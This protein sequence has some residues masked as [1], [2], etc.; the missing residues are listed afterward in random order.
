MTVSIKV[1][2]ESLVEDFGFKNLF[3]VYSGRRGVHCWV[4]D[5][6]ARA[7]TAEGRKAIVGYLELLKGGGDNARK[8]NTRGIIIHPHLSRSLAPCAELFKNVMMGNMKTFEIKDQWMKV[9][10][11]I[12]DEGKVLFVSSNV[13]SSFTCYP[14]SV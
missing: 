6:R 7:L 2:N 10:A 8:V 9:L 12:P 4:C 11:M 5:D 3:W 13:L 14:I 1:I